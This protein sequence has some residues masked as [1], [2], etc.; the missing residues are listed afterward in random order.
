MVIG[1][2]D[3]KICGRSPIPEQSMLGQE[4]ELFWSQTD[5]SSSVCR[6]GLWPQSCYR[7]SLLGIDLLAQTCL[8]VLPLLCTLRW[9][10]LGM[11]SPLEV[12]AGEFGHCR[13]QDCQGPSPFS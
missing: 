1:G 13:S 7:T 12:G 6:T 3:G 10:E 11:V 2:G 9:R 8:V 4:S 5:S